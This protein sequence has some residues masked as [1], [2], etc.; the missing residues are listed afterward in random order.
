MTFE[1]SRNVIYKKGDITLGIVDNENFEN[2]FILSFS[3]FYNNFDSAVALIL[4]TIWLSLFFIYGHS[5]K[6]WSRLRSIKKWYFKLMAFLCVVFL[7]WYILVLP[8]WLSLTIGW[9][10]VIGFLIIT[11]I[12]FSQLK[13]T[14]EY[15][16]FSDEQ[17]KKREMLKLEK[18]R[19]ETRELN[20]EIARRRKLKK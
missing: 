10:G 12:I 8:V 3:G 16:I 5:D 18:K 17:L 11:L 9:E 15:L 20:A 13:E 14:V 2:S 19:V 1:G 4:I 7:F 6:A